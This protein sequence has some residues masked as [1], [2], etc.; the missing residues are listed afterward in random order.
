MSGGSKIHTLKGGTSPFSLCMGVPSL[1]GAWADRTKVR[2][3]AFAY[4]R[5]TRHS[6]I[7]QFSQPQV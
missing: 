2:Q 5:D 3:Y 7:D 1:Q 4:C 6:E